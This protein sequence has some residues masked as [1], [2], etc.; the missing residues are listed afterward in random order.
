MYIRYI[1]KYDLPCNVFKK[2][3]IYEHHDLIVRRQMQKM[4]ISSKNPEGLTL[5]T[6]IKLL[7]VLKKAASASSKIGNKN[8]SS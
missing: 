5:V 3:P 8:L 6:N 2:Q 7:L 4:Y 1:R